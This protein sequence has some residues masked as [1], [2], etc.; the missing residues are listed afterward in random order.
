MLSWYTGIIPHL[1]AFLPPLYAWMH[2]MQSAGRPSKHLKAT[3][4]AFL[5]AL[6]MEVQLPCEFYR[7]SNGTG[8]TDAGADDTR[9]V[10]AGWWAQS[11]SQEKCAL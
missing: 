5:T 10:V 6:S 11:G 4:Q 1:K 2:A 9:A 8:A 7:S 3:A